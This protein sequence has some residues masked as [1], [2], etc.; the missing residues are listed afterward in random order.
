[1]SFIKKLK[2]VFTHGDELTELLDKIEDDNIERERMKTVHNLKLCLKHQ[3]EADH[4]HYAECNCDHCDA[5]A[6]I[7]H[8]RKLRNETKVASKIIKPNDV[9]ITLITLHLKKQRMK[10]TI[11]SKMP[12]IKPNDIST[13]PRDESRILVF[14]GEWHVASWSEDK[15]ETG[16]LILT[17]CDGTV[18]SR[19]MVDNPTHWLPLPDYDGIEIN[20][21][22]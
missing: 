20:E 12:K 3:Q 5:L 1:M 17:Y 9:V 13:A 10:T 14:D 15:W 22:S 16:W 21:T 2:L 4:S 8:F 7:D 19:A 18:N 6:T 11:I